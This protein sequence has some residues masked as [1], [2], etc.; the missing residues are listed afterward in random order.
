M[1]KA[2]KFVGY[3]LVF[4]FSLRS[5]LA[6]TA[7]DPRATIYGEDD[8]KNFYEVAAGELRD[9]AYSTAALFSSTALEDIGSK[10]LLR[11]H[12]NN[13]CSGEKFSGEKGIASCTAVLVAPKLMLTAGHCIYPSDCSRKQFV[14]GLWKQ[15]EKSQILT[16]PKE[17]VYSCKNIVAWE[18]PRHNTDTAPEF[19]L[20][21]LDREVAQPYRPAKLTKN[22]SVEKNDPLQMLGYPAGL[23]LKFAQGRARFTS[24]AEESIVETNLDAFG[25]NSGSP[26]FD[27]NGDLLAIVINGDDD[28]VSAG[29]CKQAKHCKDDECL[30]TGIMK[31][32]EILPFL[33][34]N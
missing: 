11:Y 26:V 19:A 6:V 8:R 5:A 25:G 34:R 27:K 1:R 10:Y 17:Q 22:F 3:V 15:S 21:E 13:F 9:K 4:I 18:S 32:Q 7:F 23:S 16:I 29:S 28:F 14:F 33:T 2:M 30:G 20:V 31:V 12:D 24:A